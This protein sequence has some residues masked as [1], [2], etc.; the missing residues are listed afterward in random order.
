MVR[1][2]VFD[3]SIDWTYSANDSD[4]DH[5]NKLD[6]MD[7]I[8]NINDSNAHFG[9]KSNSR[10]FYPSHTPANITEFARLIKQMAPAISEIDVEH[11]GEISEISGL[12]RN[13]KGYVLHLARELFGI[14]EKHTVI[15]PGS[16]LLFSYLDLEPICDLVRID[17]VMNPPFHMLAPMIRRGSRTLKILKIRAINLDFTDLVKDPDG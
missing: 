8:S 3:I 4:S 17:Y 6:D 11:A 1:K 7:G 5:T 9:Q 12:L 14:I 10:D 16:G 15:T 2:L 13:G